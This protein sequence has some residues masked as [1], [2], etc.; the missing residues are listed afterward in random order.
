MFR[1]MT[2][3]LLAGL[4]AV[5][6]SACGEN[7]Q[8]AAKDDLSEHVT[9]KWYI[10][11]QEPNGFS[12]VMEEANKYLNE[13]LNVTL[14]LVCIQPGD[15]NQKMQ[16]VMAAQEDYDL[17]W[18]SNWSNKY[19]P[20][21][22]NGAYLKLDEL[23]DEV[24]GMRDFYDD[25][26]WDATRVNGRIYAVP[27]NQVLYNQRS[28][29]FQTSYLDKYNVSI[30][31]ITDNQTLTD[32]YQTVRDGEPKDF[33][34]TK[35]STSFPF[36]PNMTSVTA[37]LSIDSQGK[38]TDNR[39]SNEQKWAL[40][41]DWNNRGF[42][43]SDIATLTDTTSLLMAEKIFSGYQ[44]YLPG[45][46]GKWKISYGYD[47]SS[48]PIDEPFLSRGGVQTTMTA[49]SRTSKHPVRALKLLELMHTDKYL[50]NLICYGIEG[51]DY[52]KDPNDENRM[53]RD[54]G[55]YYISEYLVGNQFLAYLVPSYEDHVWE[56]T[57]SANQAAT[58]D[59][60]IGF[61]FDPTL[62]E[63]EISQVM[64]VN[65]EFKKSLDYG[66]DDPEN[67]LPEYDSKMELAGKQKIMEE[68]QSQYD[69]WRAEQ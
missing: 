2:A 22:I 23:L 31:S 41:R 68:I 49:I 24:P 25:E 12:E 42:F 38:V 7:K 1:K 16:M 29:F 15:Y 54:S 64:A 26:I 3:L 17:V 65:T 6:L 50:L 28:I 36:Q 39:E 59:L 52:T 62:V 63:A 27:M 45:V 5:S 13:K 58:R 32:L 37:E 33:I 66:L 47:I 51:R 18:T 9:L 60:N 53:I 11:A 10:N 67:I 30:D 46:E 43:P 61:S 48:L 20:N 4:M 44:R 19:E 55:G 35:D 56:E 40:M 8:E 14:D 57:E 34:I 69:A 21:V